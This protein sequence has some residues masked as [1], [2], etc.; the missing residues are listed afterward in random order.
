[1]FTVESSVKSPTLETTDILQI[2][3]LKLWYVHAME[4]YS[5][6][7]RNKLRLGA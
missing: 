1:M 4:H 2:C 7:K 6:I 3:M 5:A